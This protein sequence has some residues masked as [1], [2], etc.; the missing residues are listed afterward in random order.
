MGQSAEEAIAGPLSRS[1]RN[2]RYFQNASGHA[3]V[4]AGSPP[5][6]TFKISMSAGTRCGSTTRNI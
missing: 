5:G 2:P 4:L 1:A 6:R 3:I